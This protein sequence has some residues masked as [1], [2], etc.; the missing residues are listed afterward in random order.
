MLIQLLHK[1][2]N[3]VCLQREL[4]NLPGKHAS[5]ACPWASGD[6]EA[7]CGIRDGVPSSAHEQDDGS[8][9]G[10]QLAM[11]KAEKS[12]HPFKSFPMLQ[13]NG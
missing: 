12:V 4:W 11:E 10:V 7:H 1:C 13:Q 2:L 3:S 5:K 9:E 8:V 6:Q